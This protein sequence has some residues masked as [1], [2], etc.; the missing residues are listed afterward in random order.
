MTGAAA[1]A[2]PRGH[3]VNRHVLLQGAVQH[4]LGCLDMTGKLP[5]GIDVNPRLPAGGGND[6][7]KGDFGAVDDQRLVDAVW[8]SGPWLR[9]SWSGFGINIAACPA[10]QCGQKNTF[11]L[12]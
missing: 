8:L 7:L 11:I 12:V 2:K 6:S 1:F 9:A 4:L 3:P 5:A 10:M